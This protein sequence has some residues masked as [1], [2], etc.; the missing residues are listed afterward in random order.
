MR[1]FASF[2]EARDALNAAD[3]V[4]I[5][6]VVVADPEFEGQIG[7]EGN[8]AMERGVVANRPRQA[9]EKDQGEGPEWDAPG[10]FGLLVGANGGP[11]E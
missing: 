9:A 7:A 5:E 3:G 8:E 11:E 6:D 2:F 10:E 4:F 1:I